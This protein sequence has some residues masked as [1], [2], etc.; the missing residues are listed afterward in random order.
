LADSSLKHYCSAGFTLTTDIAAYAG[1][2][3]S[4][5]FTVNA[6]GYLVADS[7]AD[8]MGVDREAISV[9]GETYHLMLVKF[10]PPATLNAAQSS[11][12]ATASNDTS[13]SRLNVEWVQNTDTS[14]YRM[15]LTDGAAR[16]VLATGVT[17]Y[18]TGADRVCIVEMDGTTARLHV[19]NGSA[20]VADCSAVYAGKFSAAAGQG[21]LAAS[22][23]LS[24]AQ[25]QRL[26]ALVG[27][28]SN[29]RAV[30]PD[31]NP[32]FAASLP[33]ANGSY[34]QYG[35]QTSCI[36][37]STAGDVDRWDDWVTGNNDGATT[38]NC[39]F[40]SEAGAITSA[41]P[42]TTVPTGFFGVHI[43]ALGR[44]NIPGGSKTVRTR[45]R[46]SNATPTNVDY[47]NVNLTDNFQLRDQGFHQSAA[48]NAWTQ[49]E[50]DNT[51]AG[52]LSF[53]NPANDQ[54]T[55][56]GA[57]LCGVGNAALPAIAGA[58]SPDRMRGRWP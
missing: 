5:G 50:W 16:T 45:I 36:A 47:E 1:T 53:N 27:C 43:R 55:A 57:E 52:V 54:W 29:S 38:F 4:A 26:Y 32:A 2:A 24:G 46:L 49:T 37:G 28:G 25:T 51:Q 39:E 13:T 3:G 19:W 41:F 8:I 33:N 42:N 21:R 18:A 22:A 23:N 34:D 10:L 14:H 17:D 40:A 20:W 7:T 6:G 11:P 44:H 9:A 12:V 15:R 35:D 58:A 56:I 48:G 31:G 30:A